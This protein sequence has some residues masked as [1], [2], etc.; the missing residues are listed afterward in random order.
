MWREKRHR[1]ESDDVVIA[2][3]DKT[4][5]RGGADTREATLARFESLSG[6]IRNDQMIASMLELLRTPAK[7]GHFYLVVLS[8]NGMTMTATVA[9]VVIPPPLPLSAN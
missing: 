2:I 3:D 4:P 7:A 1:F 6:D 9:S 5:D 8:P